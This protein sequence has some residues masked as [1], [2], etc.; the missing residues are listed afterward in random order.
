MARILVIA[1]FLV[2]TVAI[3]FLI[4]GDALESGFS[5]DGAVDWLR[6]HGALAPAAAVGLM[7][8]DIL[9]PIPSSAVMGAL[10][11]LYGPLV[12]G[13][14]ASAGMVLAGLLGY[15]LCRLFGRPLAHR[16]MGAR[17][18]EDGERRFRR[19]GAWIVVLSRWIPVAAEVIVFAAGLSGMPLRR[20]GAA[21]V[22]GSVPLGFFYA[23]LGHQGADRPVLTLLVCLLLPALLW[24]AVTGAIHARR[25][26]SAG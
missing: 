26:W 6:G 2:A 13:A 25:R 11:I 17:Q 22:C 21:L 19:H 5:G 24:A 16:L 12:G 10:G 7:S 23:F 14:I 8:A 4:W 15:G 20:F 1:G 18:L 9:L 3:P